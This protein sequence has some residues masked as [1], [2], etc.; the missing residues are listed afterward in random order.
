MHAATDYTRERQEVD[1]VLA[2]GIFNRA[3]NLGRLLAY[4]CEKYFEGCGEQ[5][6]EYNIAV[7]ALGRPAAFDQKHDSIVRVEAHRLRKRLR[8]YYAVEGAAHGIRIEIPSG[9]YA[10]RFVERAAP[11]ADSTAESVIEQPESG[12][13]PEA[14]MEPP[15]RP[16]NLGRRAAMLV[17]AIVVAAAAVML[18]PWRPPK[19]T[20]VAGALPSAAASAATVAAPAPEVVRLLAGHTGG[21]YVDRLGNVWQSD[22]YFQGGT[23]V[24]STDRRILGA[25]DPQLYQSRR[26]GVFGY[27]IP[28]PPGVYELRLHFVE[29]VYGEGNPAGGGET[30]RLFDVSIN[31]RKVLDD[32]DVIGDA[33]AGTVDVRVFRDISPTADGKL[34]LRFDPKANPPFV[35]AIEI[36]PGSAGKLRTIRMVSRSHPYIGANGEIWQ[37]DLYARGGQLVERKEGVAD[38]GEP[39]LYRSERFGNLHY[40]IPVTPGRYRVTLYFAELWFGPGTIGGGG[41][42]SRLFD[43]FLN[44]TALRRNFDIYKEARGPRRAVT[45]IARGVEPDAQGKLTLSLR[46]VRNYAAINAIEVVS[47]PE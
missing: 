27:D 8:E 13:D 23:A 37:P 5:I 43:I 34:H 14:P 20:G 26:E 31:G 32:F 18:I 45:V 9:Q 46:P 16:V 17:A 24:P 36:T 1:A 30:T 7:D 42:G 6:K 15:R 11:E 33:G 28:L 44:G 3:P 2:S 21:S 41:E 35:N 47:E 25:V 40:V 10:P 29:T 38:T 19:R 22:S 39:E 4:V 12:A